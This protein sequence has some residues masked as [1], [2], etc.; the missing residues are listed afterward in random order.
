[1][2]DICKPNFHLIQKT[3]HLSSLKRIPQNQPHYLIIF[4][5][6]NIPYLGDMECLAKAQTLKAPFRGLGVKGL[7]H[8]ADNHLYIMTGNLILSCL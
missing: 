5:Q 2:A 3:N 4:A 1:L 7:G 8:V 6:L